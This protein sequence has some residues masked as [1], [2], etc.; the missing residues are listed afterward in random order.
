[1][2]LIL[3][4]LK[5]RSSSL[6]PSALFLLHCSLKDEFANMTS[7]KMQEPY[8]IIFCWLLS[9]RKLDNLDNSGIDYIPQFFTNVSVIKFTVYIQDFVLKSYYHR[10]CHSQFWPEGQ[11]SLSVKV[12]MI[13]IL[14]FTVSQLF[15]SVTDN[16]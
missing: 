13:N 7:D 10:S 2:H 1:M 6:E 16:T 3:I 9:L 12:Q 15:S 5:P 14:G 11:Q 8:L 4:Y